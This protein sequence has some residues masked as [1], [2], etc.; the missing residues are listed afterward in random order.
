MDALSTLLMVII[1]VLLVFVLA[2][3]FLSF[4]LSGRSKALDQVKGQLADMVH[5]LAL[6][7]GKESTLQQSLA[8]VT[9]QL[10]VTQ[11]DRQAISDQLASVQSR[12]QATVSERDALTSQL[13]TQTKAAQ[14]NA[15]QATA[16]RARSRSCSSNFKTCSARKPSWIRRSRRIADTIQARLSDLAKLAEQT[17][18][19]QALRD[20]LEKQAE[21]ALAR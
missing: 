8:Q 9:A 3:F 11:K 18:A 5:M 15:A 10:A 6:E 16:L 20:Q 7:Q 12:L 21:G 13:T 2:Q 19:L 14:A 17:R 1:F 4:A